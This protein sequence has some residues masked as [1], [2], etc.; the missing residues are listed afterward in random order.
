MIDPV[1]NTATVVTQDDA[2]WIPLGAI[3]IPDVTIAPALQ[4]EFSS[5]AQVAALLKLMSDCGID[6][7]NLK[8]SESSNNWNYPPIKR[9]VYLHD[10]GP[11]LYT[12]SGN[13]TTPDGAVTMI[14]IN[15]GAFINKQR[16]KGLNQPPNIETGDF[17]RVLMVNPFFPWLY[18]SKV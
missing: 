4:E 5:F 9:L 13:I 14:W 10:S 1:L 15:V 2:T 7:S 12:L 6:V 11:K 18:W 17:V 16:L 8:V 3:Q